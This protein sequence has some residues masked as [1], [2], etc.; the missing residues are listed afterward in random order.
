MIAVNIVK[1]TFES[2]LQ[3]LPLSKVFISHLQIAASLGAYCYFV[4][5]NIPAKMWLSFWSFEFHNLHIEWNCNFC[6]S[7]GYNVWKWVSK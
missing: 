7:K 5:F 1:G 4:K 3:C 6:H 2:V